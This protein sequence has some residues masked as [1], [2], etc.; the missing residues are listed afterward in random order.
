MRVGGTVRLIHDLTATGEVRLLGARIDG[1]LDP[2][3]AHL[4]D[5][6]GLA[7]PSQT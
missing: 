5:D 4:A 7:R 6:H 3:G 2:T 1:S